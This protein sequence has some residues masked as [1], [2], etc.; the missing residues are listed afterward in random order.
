MIYNISYIKKVC[1][2]ISI[3]DLTEKHNIEEFKIE[4]TKTIINLIKNHDQYDIKEFEY[5]N[6]EK[7]YRTIR[8]LEN[9]RTFLESL[10]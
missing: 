10:R 3:I 6:C 5:C 8:L 7:T 1:Y 9:I 2:N 4:I